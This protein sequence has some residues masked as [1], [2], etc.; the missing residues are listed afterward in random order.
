MSKILIEI[1]PTLIKILEIQVA[2]N[3]D[4]S[5]P[6]ISVKGIGQIFI[7]IQITSDVDQKLTEIRPKCDDHFC[8][9]WKFLPKFVEFLSKV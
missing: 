3:L 8:Q 7:K 2:A 4:Q 5:F 1:G 6:K 9:T